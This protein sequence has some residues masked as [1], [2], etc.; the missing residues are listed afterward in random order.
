MADRPKPPEGY[1]TWLDY[2]VDH[3]AGWRHDEEVETPE[4]LARAELEELRE[5]AERIDLMQR[6][7]DVCDTGTN[8]DGLDVEAWA[9]QLAKDVCNARD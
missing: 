3:V 4:K 6:A 9:A 1:K 2:A 7:I 5:K 8:M